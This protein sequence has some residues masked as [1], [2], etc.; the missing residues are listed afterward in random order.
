MLKRNTTIFNKIFTLIV[1]LSIMSGALIL[2][3][4]MAQYNKYLEN[5]LIRHNKALAQLAVQSIESGYF[6]EHIP[7]ETL[8]QITK[9]KDTLFLWV[10]RP[11]GEIYLADDY[12]MW[13][14]R[15]KDDS[16]GTRELVVKDSTFFRT[17]EKIK[18]IVY[19][20]KIGK[21]EE[22]WVLYLG[23]SLKPLIDY[24]NRIMVISIISFI[25]IIIF[26]TLLSV[27]LTKS[28]I[29]PIFK[30]RDAAE[31]I[32]EGNLNIKV[33]PESR[34]EIGQ[35]AESFNGMTS[36]LKKSKADLEK[37]TK[38]LEKDVK[39]RT[40]ELQL[41]VEELEKFNKLTVGRELRM[42]ELKKKIKELEEKIKK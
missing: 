36:E 23:V 16:I 12:E 14:K 41:K 30:L 13:G 35:L 24:R 33:K 37:Y 18:L 7:F 39:N 15:I 40:K 29:N 6:I 38:N 4:T 17:G 22:Q 27:Y 25:I 42:V 19:P 32:S 34:D 20:L 28:V 11:D 3:V 31:K 1:L 5:D 2:T 9:S 21:Q 8:K 10:V 26:V